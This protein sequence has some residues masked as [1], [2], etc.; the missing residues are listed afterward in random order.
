MAE[1]SQKMFGQVVPYLIYTILLP[2][3]LTYVIGKSFMRFIRKAFR[4]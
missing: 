1:F 3:S 2:I 4:R